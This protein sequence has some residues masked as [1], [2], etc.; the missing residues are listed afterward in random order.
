M[1][2]ARGRLLTELDHEDA[3]PV[4]VIN[5]TLAR[6]EWEGRDPI[7]AEVSANNGQTWSTVVGVVADVK[8]FGLNREST[9]A[10]L[11]P[12]ASGGRP[13]GL[14]VLVR[15][16]GE[17]GAAANVIRDAVRGI[18]PDLPIENV[19]TL[20]AIRSATWRRRG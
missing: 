9:A 14:E 11:H 16:N 3:A 13:R 2:L 19:R 7:G 12:A 5:E 4:I 20:D 6:R 17:P 18:D 1:R 10:G 15:M 8:T